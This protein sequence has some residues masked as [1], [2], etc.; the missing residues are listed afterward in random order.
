MHG[1]SVPGRVPRFGVGVEALEFGNS[2]PSQL[3]VMN[4][5]DAVQAHRSCFGALAEAIP[6]F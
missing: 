1:S 4:E 2:S 3:G 5:A 6:L